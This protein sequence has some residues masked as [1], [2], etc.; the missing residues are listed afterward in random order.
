MM[1]VVVVVVVV[2]YVCV[3]ACTKKSLYNRVCPRTYVHIVR[4]LLYKR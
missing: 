3:C 1:V 4:N 2:V